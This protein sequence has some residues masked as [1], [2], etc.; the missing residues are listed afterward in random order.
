ANIVIGALRAK[1]NGYTFR[2]NSPTIFSF[3]SLVVVNSKG[4][5]S[6]FLERMPL[7]KDFIVRE[8]KQK[9]TKVVSL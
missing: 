3:V 7:R 5:N 1:V 6:F 4:P 8:S 2:V 9:V